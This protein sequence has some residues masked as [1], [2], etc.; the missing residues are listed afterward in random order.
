[1]SRIDYAESAR[2]V[3][4]TTEFR[5]LQRLRKG[6]AL[7]DRARL[8]DLPSSMRESLGL[9]ARD[10]RS[11]DAALCR[12]DEVIEHLD[13]TDRAIA[14]VTFNRGLAAPDSAGTDS[15]LENLE[16]MD[17]CRWA[18]D[19][20][21]LQWT[22][23][24][25]VRRQ[26][27][28]VIF[29]V[30]CVLMLGT[31]TTGTIGLAPSVTNVDAT[32]QLFKTMH[33]AR[34]HIVDDLVGE[35]SSPEGV[36]D[37]ILIGGRIRSMSDILREVI[38]TLATLTACDNDAS[39]RRLSV[40]SLSPTYVSGHTLP[41][42]LAA[43]YQRE[44]N[45]TYSSLISAF[46][47]ELLGMARPTLDQHAIDLSITFYDGP[48]YF[49]CYLIG[50]DTLYWGPFTWNEEDADWHG[51]DNECLRITRGA[52]HFATLRSWCVNRSRLFDSQSTARVE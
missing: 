17:R 27:D 3:G 25:S 28:R 11:L 48:P 49:Y 37:L 15:P 45:Q 35:I 43:D 16:W 52:S 42:K 13:A 18:I 2:D 6:T 33:A 32:S 8:L 47:Q 44:R 26:S 31:P 14:R 9:E 46:S 50:D 19:N 10:P 7:A 5:A 29:T 39:R 30:T 40:Y 38:R 51:P 21:Y 24:G 12:F 4:V 1:M 20:S 23:L 36:G 34:R 41:G 22:D